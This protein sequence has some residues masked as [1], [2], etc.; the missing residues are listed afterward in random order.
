MT[1]HYDIIVVGAGAAGLAAARAAKSAGRS[2]ALVEEARPGGDCTH[3]G[4]V[5]S[6]T[7]IESARRVHAACSGE[8]YGFRADVEVDF[9]AVMSRVRAAIDAI[10]QDESPALLA[11]QGIDLIREHARFVTPAAVEVDGRRVSAERFVL[12]TGGAATVPPIP[13]LRESAYLTNRTIF[14]LTERPEHLVVLGGGPIGSELAQAFRRLGS[15]V[16]IVQSGSRL[17][18]KDEPEA[19]RVLRT[20]FER[21]GVTV[22]TGAEAARVSAGPTVHLAGGGTV[23]GSHLLVA[24]GRHPV[25]DRLEL[26]VA[27]V[28]RTE[29]GL[30]RVDDY[31]RTTAEHIYAVGDC[32]APMQFTHLGDEQGRLA[33]RNAFAPSGRPGLLGGRTKWRAVIPWVT[34][35][36]PEVAHVGC[37]EAEAYRAYGDDALVSYVPMASQDRARCAGETDGFV[38]MIAA[39]R[40]PYVS[41]RA[42]YKLVGMTAVT[43]VAGEMIAEGALAVATGMLAGRIAQTVHAYP[44]WS[45]ATRLAAAQLFGTWG[46]HTARPARPDR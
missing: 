10:E 4:C 14:D 11:R 25:T 32:A 34:F 13:G 16:T 35:T 38:K 28:E 37:T 46:G 12:A 22:L 42:L 18:P 29:R 5:P 45:L 8:E 36:E 27:G 2:V 43:P 24:L 30:V 33:A 44:T 20:V 7:L 31:L 19:S 3:Y 39:P 6:K 23:T 1:T 21:E 26:D 15:R 41:A 9:P 40:A 17:V